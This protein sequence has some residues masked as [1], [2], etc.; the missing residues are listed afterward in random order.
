MLKIIGIGLIIVGLLI[1]SLIGYAW[2]AIS[3]DKTPKGD[4]S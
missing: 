1:A 2:W 3:T 4:E